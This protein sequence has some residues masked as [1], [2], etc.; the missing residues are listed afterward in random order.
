MKTAALLLVTLT[1]ATGVAQTEAAGKPGWLLLPSLFS[2]RERA[3]Q[4]G[5][6][7]PLV[8]VYDEVGQPRPSKKSQG[9]YEVGERIELPEG[10]YQVEVGNL[11][12]K[13]N[14]LKVAVKSGKVT[15]IP[16]GLIAVT[17]EPAGSQP[18]D[19]CTTWGS[20]IFVSLPTNPRP[21]PLIA[22]NRDRGSEPVGIVQVAAGYY[23]IEWHRFHVAAE[24][25]PNMALHLETG[26][27]GPMPADEYTIHLKKGLSADNPGLVLCRTRQ[28]RVL[29]R[30]YWGTY[31]EPISE[32]PFKRRVWE[33]VTVALKSKKSPYQKLAVPAVK[34]P[35]LDGPGS[36]PVKLWEDAPP[37]P[38][39][40][41]P[42]PDA[43]DAPEEP[44]GPEKPATP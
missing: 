27:I 19:T 21:G 29:A 36:E 14:R 4:P 39:P 34:G 7:P 26:L 28:T 17:V 8:W 20:E 42:T 37:E 35:F 41:P 11:Q 12:A 1:A 23:R 3:A 5:F 38:P 44:P 25:K 32:Y 15:R 22:T 13:E 40:A 43:P 6:V 30:T 24:V 31:N 33:Q 10:W 16:T 9:A 18:K 2:A